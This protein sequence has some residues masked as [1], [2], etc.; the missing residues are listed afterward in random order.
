[1][2]IAGVN[3]AWDEPDG[4]PR[5][6]L[7]LAHGAGGD[8]N[9]EL[10]C[11]VGAA[12]TQSRVATLRFN[13]PYREAG[14]RAPGSQAQSEECYRAVATEARRRGV[15]LLCGGKSYGGRIATHIAADG[16]DVD[17]LVLLSY[18][19]HPPGRP[20]KLRDEHLRDIGRPMLFIQGTRDPFATPELLTKTVAGLPTATL[21]PIEGGDHS[22]R[23]RGRKRADVVAEVA[24]AIAERLR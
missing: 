19:L 3:G 2:K 16:F 11:G 20:D 15:P 9:D 14:R 24:G 22:L 4:K 10:L 13:F 1:M 5:A 21:V 7:L 18:P 8:L 12:L 17:R 23:V 6:V